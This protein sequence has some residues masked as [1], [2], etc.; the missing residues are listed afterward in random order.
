VLHRDRRRAGAF[1][2][3]AELYDRARPRYPVELVDRLLAEGPLDVIDVGCGT[4]IAA[5]ELSA[6][7][8]R[9]L[10][11]EPDQRMAA[12]ATRRGLAVEES[13]FEH[14]DAR[15]RR[16]DLL[17]SA[18][19]WHWVDPAI[20]P[21]K[22]HAVVR[23]GGIA[24]LFWNRGRPP[25]ELQD[26]LGDV[27]RQHLREPASSSILRHGSDVGRVRDVADQLRSS[28]LFAVVSVERF[29]NP[30]AYTTEG[31][32][33]HLQTQSQHLVLE[34]ARRRSLLADVASAIESFGGRFV[35]AYET[36]LVRARR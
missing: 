7:G 1:G 32:I 36:W 31:W 8:C 25:A 35:V 33:D 23:D 27:Y 22:A 19:A 26:A 9:V 5:A 3:V 15:G 14:W 28:R 21:S 30:V 20:G 2:E 24:A 18:Q 13:S 6:R 34:P 4:G 17:M 11:V 16:F 29:P 10:G 12:V